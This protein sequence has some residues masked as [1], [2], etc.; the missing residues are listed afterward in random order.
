MAAVLFLVSAIGSGIARSLVE[1]VIY[2][3]IGGVGVGMA[4]MISPLWGMRRVLFIGTA[5]AI[6]Q[7]ITGI[8]VFLYYAPEIFKSVVSGT[9]T[10]VALL[11]TIVVGAV[12]LLFTVVAIWTVDKLGRRPLMMIGS[13][14]GESIRATA[15]DQLPAWN[16][17][18][19]GCSGSLPVDRPR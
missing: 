16:Q 18:S 10:D 19:T 9:A 6:L 4:S 3:I 15:T 12:N 7:Q 17:S 8:N 5:L 13:V 11:Q 2:R 1:F 14:G